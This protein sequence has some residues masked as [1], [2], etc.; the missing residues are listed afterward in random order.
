MLEKPKMTRREFL[1]GVAAVPALA[2]GQVVWLEAFVAPSL[3]ARIAVP[4]AAVGT[5]DAVLELRTYADPRVAAEVWGRLSACGGLLTRLPDPQSLLI[6][7]ESLAHRE[8]TW[9]KFQAAPEW[10]TI[11]DHHNTS[12]QFSLYRDRIGDAANIE[13]ARRQSTPAAGG[14]AG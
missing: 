11:R 5:R 10:E 9:R 13:N 14:E 7:F 1:A 12:Y 2:G 8:Q 6:R 4:A 3:P